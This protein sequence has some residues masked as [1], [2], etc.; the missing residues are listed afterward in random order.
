MENCRVDW[1]NWTGEMPA[2]LM[3]VVQDGKVLL[4]RK[5]RGIG[6]GKINGPGGKIDP[7]ETPDECV[8]RECQEELHITPLNPV[9]MGELWF[10]MSDIPDIHCHVFM[11]TEFEGTP[12]P[13]DEA[14]P[15]WTPIEEI[16]YD[17]MWED[18]QYWL[19]QMLQGQK[20]LGKFVFEGESIQWRE[21]IWESETDTRWL[22]I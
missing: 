8:V 4:I 22:F 18:D 11:A 21:I 16:P 6:K 15:L 7:G 20:F 5:M 19:P 9:K 17:E 14:I 12:T 2:T 1:D 10:A 13:T 3:F